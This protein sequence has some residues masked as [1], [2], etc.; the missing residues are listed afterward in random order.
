M[1][2]S[3][4]IILIILY[5]LFF[6]STLFLLI[7]KVYKKKNIE[8]ADF[9][10]LFYI[11]FYG[12]VPICT[13]ISIKTG[14][15][16]S[17]KAYY[18]ESNQ[19]YLKYFVF[20]IT[21]LFYIIFNFSYKFLERKKFKFKI[22]KIP[23]ISEKES[24]FYIANATCLFIGWV[25]LFLYTLAYGGIIG[26]FKYAEQIRNNICPINNNLTYFQPFTMILTI[27]PFNYL[28]LI[29]NIKDK[30]KKYKITTWLLF[31]ISLIGAIFVLLIIDSRS[32]M[33]VSLLIILYYI[34][35]SELLKFNKKDIF[36]FS[37][38]SVL[39][40]LILVNSE[41][42]S[43]FLHNQNRTEQEHQINEFVSQEFGF[44]YL[45]NL[46]VLYRKIHH[47]NGRIR[48]FDN[49][50][51]LSLSLL[52]RS[53]QSKVT[54]NMHKYNTKLIHRTTGTVPSDLITS[55]IYSLGY[56][57]P[58]IFPIWIA[59]I[60]YCLNGLIVKYQKKYDYYNVLESYFAFYI[61]L[62][63]VYSYDL[64]SI[65]FSCFETIVFIILYFAFNSK[66]LKSVSNKVYDYIK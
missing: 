43:G 27:L 46:N 49:A 51:G 15:T 57:G 37:I 47:T 39:L 21:I 25:A 8:L 36:K 6:C 10:K 32:R 64:A 65:T 56:I 42:I 58:I 53:I 19:D 4:F 63:L 66:Y 55:S 31:L 54:M 17:I 28:T 22:D 9:F 3:N 16:S 7:R 14:K 24:P 41:D 35:K 18:L 29:K 45:N 33:I 40:F 38:I 2:N 50:L 12:L 26:T 11:F 59:L 60:V 34:F 1:R 52:P 5:S 23:S 20:I 13:L 62:L 48:I 30:S 61:C 44:S